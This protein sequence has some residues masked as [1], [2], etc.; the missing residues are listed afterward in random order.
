VLSPFVA[1]GI[2]YVVAIAR[3]VHHGKMVDDVLS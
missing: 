1:A 2:G 3:N